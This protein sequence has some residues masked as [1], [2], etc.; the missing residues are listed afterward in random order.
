MNSLDN[1]NK[2]I[3]DFSVPRTKLIGWATKEL[4]SI[5]LKYNKKKTLKLYSKYL[6]A[7]N[8]N[9]KFFDCLYM[10]SPN[11]KFIELTYF[12]RLLLLSRYWNRWYYIDLQKRIS[13]KDKL[14]SSL[15]TG[16]LSLS[17]TINN[18]DNISIKRL[19]KMINKMRYCG[20]ISQSR[21]E[22]ILNYLESK[23]KAL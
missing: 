9:I 23:Y 12:K 21:L 5:K 7:I 18:R 13:T 14:V 16:S 15:R 22:F 10:S 6:P 20:V 1:L 8:T 17:L 3:K 4:E 2:M 19:L 11:R